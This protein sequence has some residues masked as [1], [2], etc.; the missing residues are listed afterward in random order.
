MSDGPDAFPLWKMVL[1]IATFLVVL[2]LLPGEEDQSSAQV[3]TN[4]PPATATVQH[5]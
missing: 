5:H 2:W 3:H 4:P 1:A